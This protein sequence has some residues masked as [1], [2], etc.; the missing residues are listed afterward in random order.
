M[1]KEVTLFSKLTAIQSY[2]G[3]ERSGDRAMCGCTCR[4]PRRGE[5]RNLF[6]ALTLLGHAHQCLT[7]QRRGMNFR[8]ICEAYVISR[9]KRTPSNTFMVM[10]SEKQFEMLKTPNASQRAYEPTTGSINK[11]REKSLF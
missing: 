5:T 3:K 7:L 8:G 10:T 6:D 4:L 1:P 2:W 11:R 9:V